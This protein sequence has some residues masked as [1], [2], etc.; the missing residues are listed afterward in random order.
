MPT[1]NDE[2]KQ[3]MAWKS[4]E[5]LLRLVEFE[6]KDYRPE[7]IEIAE[8]EIARRGLSR[9]LLREENEPAATL[10]EKPEEPIMVEEPDWS[11]PNDLPGLQDRINV[12]RFR[13]LV[14]LMQLALLMGYAA[15]NVFEASPIPPEVELFVYGKLRDAPAESQEFTRRDLLAHTFTGLNLLSFVTALGLFFFRRWARLL[16]LLSIV[17]WLVFLPAAPLDL[18]TGTQSALGYVTTL[19]EG[20]VLALCYLSSMKSKFEESAT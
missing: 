8:A 9:D 3:R 16:L 19:L 11:A 14:F 5:E 6:A 1:Q 13:M 4:D 10:P 7:A 2:I 18:F 15:P 17:A 20:M 12:N